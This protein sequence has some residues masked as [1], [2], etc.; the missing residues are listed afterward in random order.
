MVYIL[1]AATTS[2]TSSQ[3]ARTN[4]P[5]PRT[6]LYC[7]ARPGVVQICS[8]ARV[9]AMVLRASRH[10]RARRPRSMG[11]L[12]RLAL[13]KYHEYDAPREQPRGRSEER[14]VGKECVST[15]RSRWSP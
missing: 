13:Y 7:S 10:I 3:L 5:I 4:P 14:R 15:C 11:Y 8:Q 2:L 12:M 1:A 6:D 9:G